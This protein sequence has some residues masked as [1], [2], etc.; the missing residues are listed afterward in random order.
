MSGGAPAA[1]GG[2]DYASGMVVSGANGN[3]FRPGAGEMPPLLAGR[4]QDL[5][6]AEKRLAQLAAGRRPARGLLY[7]GPRGN[8][9]TVLLE[10]IGERARELGLRAERFPA[11]AFRNEDRFVGQL[12]RRA[13]AAGGR[14][15]GVKVASISVTTAPAARLADHVAL[16]AKWVG[17]QAAPLVLLLDEVHAVAPDPARDFFEAAQIAGSDGLSFVI[18]AAGTPDAPRALR[19]AGTFTERMLERRRLGRLDREDTA[20]ALA[21]PAERE[22]RP[23][24]A[25]ALRRLVR[26]SQNYPYFVQ[27]L[28][29]AA[30]DAAVSAGASRIGSEAAARGIGAARREIETFYQERFAEARDRRAHGAL[31]PLAARMIGSGGRIGD[32]ELDALMKEAAAAADGPEDPGA[33]QIA[34]QDLGMVWEVSSGVWEMGIPNF[35]E[36]VLRR[37]DP[38]P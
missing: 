33:L 22:G 21:R 29:S 1:V 16:F 5:E 31:R 3:P 37:G 11:S 27:L 12:Q 30:W 18:V 7:Y 17:G 28:G 23:I 4:E 14:M 20:A 19:R 36:H 24:A 8:G 38:A 25:G 15:T 6:L 10:R 9:K 2:L 35:A 13:G 32:A 26:E 34:L